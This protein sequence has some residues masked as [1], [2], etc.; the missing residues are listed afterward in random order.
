MRTTMIGLVL[1]C[2]AGASGQYSDDF[3]RPD[4]AIGGDWAA[5]HGTFATFGISSNR[6]ICTSTLA[7]TINTV[8]SVS[9]YASTTYSVDVITNG[10]GLQYVALMIGLGGSRNL[11]I[12]VQNQT[13]DGFGFVGFYEG[14]N[15]NSGWAA[16]AFLDLGVRFQ[17]AKMTVSF[18]DPDTIVLDFDTDFNGTPDI[19]E[20][21]TGV[22]ALAGGFGTAVGI[23]A[24]GSTSSPAT[25]DNFVIDDG[26]AAC[27]ADCEG[28]GDLDVFD[29][30]CFQGEYANQTKYADCEGDGD[31][32][33]FDFLCF[34]GAYANGCN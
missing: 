4:G 8:A 7:A 19:T 1:A 10:T 26:S 16:S 5:L 31:W 22:S 34:Q 9:D 32:D 6:G 33:V 30:L 29:F 12:K 13:A 2:A 24:F 18:S 28:D 27:Y 20:I 17:D 11:F 21:R 14:N 3:N 25:F 15:L 23:G